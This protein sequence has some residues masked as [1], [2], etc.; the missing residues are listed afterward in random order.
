MQCLNVLVQHGSSM[1]YNGRDKSVTGSQRHKS[2]SNSNNNKHHISNGNGMTNG[3]NSH[4][5]NNGSLHTS[6]NSN[7]SKQ[8][9]RSN[10]IKSKSSSTLSSDVEPFYLHHPSSAVVRKNSDAHYSQQ[11]RSSSE[12]LYGGSLVP[13]NDGLYVNPMRNGMFTPPSPNGS[14]S[15]E[16]FFLHDPKEV[17]YNRVRDLFDSDCS[18]VKHSSSINS[19]KL[20]HLHNNGTQNSISTN[21]SGGT[22]VTIQADVHSSSSG[23]GSGSDDSVSIPSSMNSPKTMVNNNSHRSQSFNRHNGNH[24]N[25]MHN[26]NNGHNVGNNLGTNGNGSNML[27]H[28]NNHKNNMMKSNASHDHDYEDIYL[29]REESRKNQQKYNIGRS[30]SRDSGSHSRSA[31][32]SSTRST[33]V[34]MQYSNHVS[35]LYLYIKSLLLIYFFLIIQRI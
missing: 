29:V 35:F 32:A 22:A 26:M 6:C 16:S 5:N 7:S 12:K 2:N 14:I 25:N 4:N 23:A 31:S 28:Q 1:D 30:R 11:S 19:S 17:I 33:D 21:G 15:G 8:T 9:S 24:S 20:H 10:T 18:S 3:I 13:Q 34:V 27:L